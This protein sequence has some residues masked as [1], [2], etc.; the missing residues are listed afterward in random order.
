MKAG[1]VKLP[2]SPPGKTTLKK[3]SL[4]RVKDALSGLRQYFATET[5]LKIMKNVF[6]FTLKLFSF[7]KFWN[8]CHD[9]FGYV[10]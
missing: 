8:F 4:I 9:F 6:S 5:S 3:S 2:P 1:V 7:S 10:E